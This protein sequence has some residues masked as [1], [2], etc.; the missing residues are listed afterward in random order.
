MV[1]GG[2]VG[3]VVGMALLA[4]VIA[5]YDPLAVEPGRSLEPP[6]LEHLMGSDE[7]GRDILSR[8]M[9]G[10]RVSL[11]VGATAVLIS[12]TVGSL[13][14]LVAGYYTQQTDMLITWFT[15]VLLAFP[16]ILLA[17]AVVAVLRPG[18]LQAA[19]AVGIAGIPRYVRLV[20]GAVFSTKNN[21]YVDAARVLGCPTPLIL[22]RH[23]A[24]NVAAPVIVL[25]SLDVANAIL[26]TA[27]LSFLGIGAQPPAAEWGAMISGGRTYLG[28]AW[29]VAT[30]PGMAMLVTLLGINLL[31]DGLRDFLDP[32]RSV[33]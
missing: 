18:I 33:P 1:G 15:N 4:P 16:G 9:H 23:I 5:P 32:R 20:R 29:W 25:S 3:L 22:G 8:V 27:A 21:L 26:I 19:I 30:L 14:G 11:V 6:G 31:G 7:L 17:L 13:L 24:P 28:T 12:L 2:I 10:A